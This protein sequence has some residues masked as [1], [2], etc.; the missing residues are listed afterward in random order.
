MSTHHYQ[1]NFSTYGTNGNLVTSRNNSKDDAQD[2]SSQT[3]LIIFLHPLKCRT[4]NNEGTLQFSLTGAGYRGVQRP[5][6]H[7]LFAVFLIVSENCS[8]RARNPVPAGYRRLIPSDLWFK[9]G[10][11]LSNLM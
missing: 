7:F 5:C 2:P 6:R 4:I 8:H 11:H 1:P 10:F 3:L 9:S